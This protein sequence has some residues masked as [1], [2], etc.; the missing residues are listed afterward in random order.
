MSEQTEEIKALLA[1]YSN[2]QD[3]ITL[4]QLDYND[5][6]LSVIPQEIQN[7]LVTVDSEF[8]G[9]EEEARGKLDKIKTLIQEKMVALPEAE[10]KTIKEAGFMV[11]AKG[12]KTV[13]SMDEDTLVKGFNMLAMK[14]PTISAEIADILEMAEVEK[15][16]SRSV[17]LQAVK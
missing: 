17:A 9:K 3:A 7:A 11:V 15:I 10:Y 6:R 14:Y 13:R 16:T 2:F 5:A 12:G 1:Q 8:G 4:I